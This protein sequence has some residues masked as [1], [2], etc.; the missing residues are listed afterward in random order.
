MPSIDPTAAQLQALAADAGK[1]G[2][3]VMIN[4]LRFRATA[5][6]PAGSGHEPCSGRDAYFQRY[7]PVATEKLQEIGGRV[8]AAGRVGAVVIG[9]E[10][11]SWEEFL[12]VQYPSRAAFLE[13][14]GQPDYRA[15]AVHRSAALADSRLILVESPG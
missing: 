4:L 10:G 3:I 5:E 9:P 11:E 13:M 7:A 6:Y 12:L 8:V 14:V 1:A 15:A 2:R